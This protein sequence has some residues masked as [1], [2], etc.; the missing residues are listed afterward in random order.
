MQI[1]LQLD[2]TTFYNLMKYFRRSFSVSFRCRAPIA[3]LDCMEEFSGAGGHL[4]FGN[5][6]FL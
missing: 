4:D 3:S 5:F 2:Y 1:F 6:F